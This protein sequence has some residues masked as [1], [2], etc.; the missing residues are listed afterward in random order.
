MAAEEWSESRGA[1]EWSAISCLFALDVTSKIRES[2]PSS[3]QFAFSF[4]GRIWHA[5]GNEPKSAAAT[6][7]IAAIWEQQDDA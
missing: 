6:P 3:K 7:A 4:K 5:D 2:Q 1:S